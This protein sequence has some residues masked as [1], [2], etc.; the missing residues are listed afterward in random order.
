V[1]LQLNELAEAMIAFSMLPLKWRFHVFVLAGACFVPCLSA[2]IREIRVYHGKKVQCIHGGFSMIGRGRVCG[3]EG[4]ARVFSGTVKSAIEISDTDKKL[5]LIPDEVFSGDR[6]SEVT[7]TV[8][9]ACMPQGQPEIQ[10]GQKWLFYLGEGG[11]LPFDSPSKPLAEAQ[12]DIATLRH[13]ARLTGH[14]AIITGSV[15]RIGETEDKLNPVPVANRKVVAKG[16]LGEYVASTNSHGHF[17]FE[18][19]PDSYEVI[20]DT[21]HGLR[22]AESMMPRGSTYIANGACLN[23]D[24]T[25]LRDGKLAGRV[26]TRDGK[27]ARF[28]KVAIIPVSPVHPQFT[29]DTDEDGHFEVGGR[30]AGQYIIGV[31]LLAPFNSAEWRSRVYYPGAPTRQQAKIIELGDGEWRTDLNFKLPSSSSGPRRAELASPNETK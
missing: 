3:T 21:E 5:T 6:D 13:L 8:D 15:E 28:V 18:L 23:I 2:E 25:L 19:P 11:D 4:Y 1:K 27:P 29:V 31:G 12:D 22:E 17:E 10:A 30:Q 14:E 7:A 26:T 16:V 24:F 9:Q 20:V